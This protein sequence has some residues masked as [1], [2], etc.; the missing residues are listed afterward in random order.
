MNT[1]KRVLAIITAMALIAGAGF[2]SSA[3]AAQDADKVADSTADHGKFAE[4][5][6]DFQSGPDVTKACLV[7]HTEAAKQIHKTQH[8]N[9]EYRNPDTGQ[10]LGKRHVINNFCT[11]AASNLA[12][13]ASCHIG[14]GMKDDSF[15][16]S[17]EEKVDCLVCHDN[18]GKYR[19]PL[20]FAGDV[21]TVNTE[22]P[23]HSGKIIRGINLREIAQKVGKTRRENCG[24]CH[25]YGGGGDGV[26]HGDLDSSLDA[27]DHALDVHMDVD[28]NNFSCATCH[29]TE[30]H[31][32]PGSRYA[33]TAMDPGDAHLRG[34]AGAGNPATCQACHGQVPHKN[35]AKLNDHTDIVACQTCH[36]PAFARGDVP[37]RMVWDWSTAGKRGSDGEPLEITDDDSYVTYVGSKGDFVLA[38]NVTPDYVW[39]NGTVKYTLI[40][41]ELDTAQQPIYINRFEGSASDGKSMIWP[42]KTFRGK[43]PFDPVSKSLVVTHLYGHDDTGYW[44][45]LDWEKAIGA[46]MATANRPFS[47]KVD[48]I[49]TISQ[50]PITHMV[51]PKEQ[52]LAC[53][54]CHVR[55][56]R[57]DQVEGIH[58]PGRDH[59]PLLDRLGWLL[60]AITLAVVLLHG[61]VRI[62][63]RKH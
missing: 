61:A 54:D 34:K 26:K 24:A 35:H 17:A 15:D 25:F 3:A 9:W 19:K 2:A 57:L 18:T 16:F 47:G 43:Q 51:A 44:T 13:C 42:I 12:D 33:P 27:P 32:V 5:N 49:E 48:F 31:Q 10:L 1:S 40:G 28:G 59:N 63:R 7:C 30:G 6:K 46:G 36:I 62:A 11:S 55:G 41:D 50:W 8:W 56:G 23:P 39:F 45:N 21:V 38:E 37:T 4:L 14:Y 22:Y 20:G 52:A 53:N 29:Q 58:I 60:A